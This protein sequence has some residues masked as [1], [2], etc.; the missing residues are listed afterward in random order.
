MQVKCRKCFQEYDN[1]Y[2]YCPHCGEKKIVNS[3]AMDDTLREKIENAD[4]KSRGVINI[5]LII[6]CLALSG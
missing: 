2:D 5:I 1:K 4:N 3:A 6:L